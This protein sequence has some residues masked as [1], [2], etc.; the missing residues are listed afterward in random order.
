MVTDNHSPWLVAR[1]RESRNSVGAINSRFNLQSFST[2]NF[3][4]GGRRYS[5]PIGS[6]A[7]RSGIV[8]NGGEESAS[9]PVAAPSNRRQ[10][11]VDKPGRVT[12]TDAGIFERLAQC[13][14]YQLLQ[15]M[16]LYRERLKPAI[17]DGVEELVLLSR[18]DG[19]FSERERKQVIELTEKGCQTESSR[20]LLSL[21]IEKGAQARKATWEYFAEMRNELPKL[22]KILKEI[23][24]FDVQQKHKETLRSETETLRVN[25]IL[26]REKVKVEQYT[27]LTII[28]I[29]RDRRLVERELLAKGREHERWRKRH[30]GGEL[31]K[32]RT[33]QL[34]QSS[35]TRSK[36]QSGNSAAVVG[37]A[38]I[39]KTTMVQKIVNDWATGKIY[40][41]FQFV[42]S[43]KFRDLN[44]IKCRITLKELILNQYPYFG[45]NLTVYS[46]IQG[47][48]LPG[49]SVLVTTR[50]TAL[51]LLEKAE[52]CVRAEILGFVGEERKEYFIRHFEDQTVA[53][54]VFKYVQENEILYTMSYNPSYCWILA[55]ALGPFFTQ[56]VRDPQRV[57]KTVTQFYSC[58]IYNILKNNGSEIESP[59]D[60]FLSLGQMAFRG[61]SEKK[62]VFTDGDLISYNVQPSQFLSGFLMELLE[63][64]DSTWS[65]VYTFPHVTFQEFVAALAQFLNPHPADI[66]KSLNEAHGEDD[67]R[68]EVLGNNELGDSGVKLVSAALKNPECKIQKLG[69][70]QV[71]LT[72]SGAE[73]LSSALSANRSLT[74]LDLSYNNALGDS[75]VRVVTAALGNPECKIQ[76]LG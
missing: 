23:Q 45:N 19:H 15:L 11:A 13:T 57:P 74:E 50:P 67:G 66:L 72:D 39:G 44:L 27:E 6:T 25:T 31:E 60:V 17:E 30:L 4:Q 18:M 42:F 29:L 9:V 49:C 64:E 26:K 21:V 3:P 24:E 35:F 12:H 2:K 32:I 41:Q 33:D 62:V 54:A 14:D 76:K 34:F 55:L 56:R 59:R 73:D 36:S 58:Y 46:L 7:C 43:F 5:T 10:L 37:V 65:V 47:K 63:R 69:L 20:L 61:V 8:R 16:N 22:D 70:D 51:H 38:G 68:F 40:Q 28:S 1:D 53:A 75:G 71:H 52:I 48:L